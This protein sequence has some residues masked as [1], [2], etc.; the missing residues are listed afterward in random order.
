MLLIVGCGGGGGE[1]TDHFND[2]KKALDTDEITYKA[3]TKT[4]TIKKASQLIA[5]EIEENVVAQQN[6]ERTTT[7]KKLNNLDADTLYEET[8]TKVTIPLSSDDV[9]RKYD[10]NK[11]YFET[12]TCE[13]K[14]ASIELNGVVA[15][16]SYSTFV[17][18]GSSSIS[19][20]NIYILVNKDTKQ[21]STLT[22]TYQ[23]ESSTTT[24]I[25]YTFK[26]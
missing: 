13:E 20:F 14:G 18:N 16:K 24:T 25:T 19:N 4:I 12:Y 7:T 5:E 15:K 17:P 9:F 21:L 10:M 23:N 11:A 1:K 22:F 6:V 2:I 3:Y 26:Y 8:T